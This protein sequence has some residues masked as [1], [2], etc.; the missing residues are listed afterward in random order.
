[1]FRVCAGHEWL[2]AEQ[3]EKVCKAKD[4]GDTHEER[5]EK[6]T[7]VAEAKEAEGVCDVLPDN[8]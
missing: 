2:L 5:D 1:M 8:L 3:E 7:G 6:L 4:D